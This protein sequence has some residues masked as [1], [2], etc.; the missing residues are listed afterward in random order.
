VGVIDLD[1]GNTRR[2][3]VLLLPT[4]G[5]PLSGTVKV[6]VLSQGKSVQVDGI[7]ATS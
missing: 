4:L 7:V 6:T 2:R 1:A 5:T 3:Q